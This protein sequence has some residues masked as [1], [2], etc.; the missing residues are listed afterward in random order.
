MGQSPF[1]L[2]QAYPPASDVAP[3]QKY[4]RAVVD[5]LASERG[6]YSACVSPGMYE[7]TVEISLTRHM[8]R[9]STSIAGECGSSAVSR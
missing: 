8:W 7:G 4:Q 9:N 6:S 5:S 1:I 3:L 2:I